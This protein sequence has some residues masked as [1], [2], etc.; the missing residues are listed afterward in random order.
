[1]TTSGNYEVGGV[2][3][4]ARSRTPSHHYEAQKGGPRDYEVVT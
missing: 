1:M 2:I 4:F 3:V